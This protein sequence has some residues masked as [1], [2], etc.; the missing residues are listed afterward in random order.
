M[1]MDKLTRM[2]DAETEVLES[3]LHFIKLMTIP[4]DGAEFT[5]TTDHE[6]IEQWHTALAA[7]ILRQKQATRMAAMMPMV[8]T[9]LD[10]NAE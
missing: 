8:F 5:I 9:D 7:L 10:D 6:T 1:S 4:P 3:L 2:M